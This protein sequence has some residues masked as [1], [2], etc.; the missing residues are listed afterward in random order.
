METPSIGRR[1]RR[2]KGRIGLLSIEKNAQ[3]CYN[4]QMVSRLTLRS[5]GTGMLLWMV[6]GFAFAQNNNNITSTISLAV[7]WAIS[8][9]N[10]GVW[11][12][13]TMLTQLLDTSLFLDTNMMNLLNEVWQ[14]ARNLV[15]IAFAIVLIGAAVYTVVTSK[16]EFIKDHLS[17]FVLAVVLV[18][19]SWFIPRVIIDVGNVAAATVFDIPSFIGNGNVACTYRSP[20]KIGMA[21]LPPGVNACDPVVPATNPVTYTCRC[22]AVA[23]AEFFVDDVRAAQLNQS[24]GWNPIL[25]NTL[26]V[27]LTD[28][29]NIQNAAPSS[30]VLNGLI[31]NHARLVGLASVP[32]AV[33][34][35]Q[36]KALIMF[37][38]QEAVVLLLH[39]ALFFPLAAMLLAFAIRIPVL[40][41]TIAFMPFMVLKFVVPEQYTGE[42]PQ[43][44]WEN[45]LKAAFLPAIVGIPLTIGFIMVNA[46]QQA[47]LLAPLQGI[48][49]KLTNNI[50]DYWQL[51]WLIMVIGIIWVG[52][53]STLEKMGIMAMGSQMI[54]GA[55]EG[56][57]KFALKAPL[58]M[59]VIPGLGVSPLALGRSLNPANLNATL[60]RSTD[61]DDFLNQMRGGGAGPG[62][63]AASARQHAKDNA[64][65]DKL[66]SHMDDL[67]DAIKN[68][69]DRTAATQAMSR[70]LGVNIR[71]DHA[72]EDL[73]SYRAELQK[74]GADA[75]KLAD[76]DAKITQI[77]AAERAAPPT[78]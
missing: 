7:T 3:K 8:A 29:G 71:Q 49:F 50:S 20:V 27:Q 21:N 10:I 37:L 65:M 26:Y 41:L 74:A 46:G 2:G 38:L 68:G 39:V 47:G 36:P 69:T 18:N 13:F 45:F 15:N 73:K 9:L 28:L 66:T 31:I 52:V 16:K 72:S 5:I 48:Q 33:N 53:F 60:D 30:V 70:D 34:T 61:F 77:E 11:I 24:V 23:D 55:G 19:F 14:L 51:L 35:T 42:Y 40:W 64:Q 25:G 12:V 57:G 54:K 59:P 32:P 75:T 43:K 17:K 1:G 78:P 67:K 56:L 58:S 44:I 62:G 63:M 76:I 6:P 4:N 22:A